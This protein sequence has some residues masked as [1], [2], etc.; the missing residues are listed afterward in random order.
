MLY[1]TSLF[2]IPLLSVSP[3]RVYALWGQEILSYWFFNPQCLGES[4]ATV[5]TQYMFI[6]ALCMKEHTGALFCGTESLPPQ[7]STFAWS[8]VRDLSW[9]FLYWVGCLIRSEFSFHSGLLWLFLCPFITIISWATGDN[10][11]KWKG[12]LRNWSFFSWNLSSNT[13]AMTCL[14]HWCTIKGEGWRVLLSALWHFWY[15]CSCEHCDYSLCLLPAT[16]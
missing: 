12:G 16:S 5:G 7:V 2:V 10:C 3:T 11:T 1:S 4:C 15:C 9:W 6:V 13:K 14:S 8:P